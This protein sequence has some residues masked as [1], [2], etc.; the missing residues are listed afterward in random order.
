MTEDYAAVPDGPHPQGRGIRDDA[1]TLS[2]LPDDAPEQ[3]RA[4]LAGGDLGRI[5]ADGGEVVRDD[6]APSEATG[7]AVSGARDD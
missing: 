4:T 6:E 5:P 1:P 2:G 7:P 3:L